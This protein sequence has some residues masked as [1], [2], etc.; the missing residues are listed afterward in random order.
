MAGRTSAGTAYDIRDAK[1][2]GNS[3]IEAIFN[4]RL[5]SWSDR[6]G[7]SMLLGDCWAEHC[8]TQLDRMAGDLVPIPGSE[9]F[10]LRRVLRLDDN[11]EVEREAN[12]NQL[13]NPDFLLIGTGPEN[14]TFVQAADAKFAAD[15]IKESQVSVSAVEDL[16]KIP[17]SGATRALLRKAVEDLSQGEIVVVPGVFL[18]PESPFTDALL[19]RARRGPRGVEPGEILVRLPVDPGALFDTAAPARLIPTMAR[20]DRLPVSPR[21]NLLAAVYYLRTSC[22]CFH[23]W[24]EQTRPYFDLAPDLEPPEPGV[25]AAEVARRAANTSSAYSLLVGWHRD[26]RDI[27]SARKSISDAVSLPVGMD[28]IRSAVGENGSGKASAAVRRARGTLEG[29]YRKKLFDSMGSIHSDDPRPVKAII[30][31]IRQRSRELR[32]DLV[33]ELATMT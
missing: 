29:S 26:L 30:D 8:R 18:S 11:P 10:R 15:R 12:L 1:L 23:L 4:R 19:D 3:L 5:M 7:A 28:E 9:H 27:I 21:E 25:I 6:G 31:D 2:P 33:R 16:L 20:V 24:D 14:E 13:E 32:P 17:E 22:A